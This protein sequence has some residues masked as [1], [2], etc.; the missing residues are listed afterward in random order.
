MIG[1]RNLKNGQEEPSNMSKNNNSNSNPNN[2]SLA[3]SSYSHI[4]G[5]LMAGFASLIMVLRDCQ[6]LS[7]LD[8]LTLLSPFLAVV[9]SN[10]TNGPIT[11]LA[12]SSIDKFLTYSF[13][14][15]HSSSLPL[16]M[17][18]ISAAGTHC[19]FEASDSISDEIVLLKILDVLEHALT[20]PVGYTLTDEAVCQMMETG[21]SMCCQ[22]RL[23]EMLR[24][25]AERTMQVMVSAVFSR[26]K[27]L[28]ASVD[29]FIPD[30]DADEEN[31]LKER[32][33]MLAPDPRSGS[34]PAASS[35]ANK[36]RDRSQSITQK[37]S[38]SLQ[39]E[40]SKA[41]EPPIDDE[42]Q[43]LLETPQEPAPE[44]ILNGPTVEEE[45][46]LNQDT[47]E[48]LDRMDYLR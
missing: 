36:E 29:D 5:G 44:P 41:E 25:S 22:M 38:S 11:A 2:N 6:D 27:N 45:E 47:A 34:I 26:L 35:L 15:P 21:L 39:E 4:R 19:R 16:A 13:I 30:D 43:G 23:S 42:K 48:D 3:G 1:L 12:L 20:G 7:Q 46:D 8:A 14:H 10:E 33:R 32:L 24:R 28:D 31:G 40:P 37:S 17:S 18:Q 9:R